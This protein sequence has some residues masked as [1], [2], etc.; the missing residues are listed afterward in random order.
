MENPLTDTET[1]VQTEN[2]EQSAA[3]ENQAKP[4]YMTN[5]AFNAAI[6]KRNKQ[7]E[8]KIQEMLKDLAPKKEAE[9]VKPSSPENAL[10]ADVQA[11]LARAELKEQKIRQQAKSQALV[12]GLLER[13]VKPELV[14]Y[15][16]EYHSKFV[17]Y[18]DPESDEL[19]YHDAE[20][21]IHLKD[22][23]DAII[24]SQASQ[25]F[26]KG[27]QI[28]GSAEMAKKTSTNNAAQT[29]QENYEAQLK[30]IGRRG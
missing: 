8:N 1:E 9:A 29:A 4:N 17:D 11:R 6:A 5:E 23:L 26:L 20:G 25:H 27:P 12:T 15:I 10:L 28:K 30:K 19:V 14:N 3:E 16:A 7:L 22:A 13:N 2:S 21:T 24:Q 18:S